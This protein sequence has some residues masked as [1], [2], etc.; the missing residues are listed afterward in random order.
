MAKYLDY[1]EDDEKQELIEIDAKKLR[2]KLRNQGYTKRKQELIHV[3]TER[4]RRAEAKAA[5]GL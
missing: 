4:R 5:K 1:M 3:A 2:I